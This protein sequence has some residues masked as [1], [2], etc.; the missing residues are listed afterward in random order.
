MQFTTTAFDE[1]H[2]IKCCV[3]LLKKETKNGWKKG[4][5][6]EGRIGTAYLFLQPKLQKN[7]VYCLPL[8]G[9][10]QTIVNATEKQLA[11]S[12]AQGRLC[13]SS[14]E[15]ACVS[16]CVSLKSVQPPSSSDI[17]ALCFSFILSSFIK[18]IR[19]PLRPVV[20]VTVHRHQLWAHPLLIFLR[21]EWK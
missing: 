6:W 10:L 7:K 15:C 14:L 9:L 5:V 13:G 18:P 19:V 12:A 11:V 21:Q 17:L 2:Y 3:V 4:S 8:T 16:V 1:R 20:N